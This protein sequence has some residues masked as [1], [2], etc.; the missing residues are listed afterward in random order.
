[1]EISE[2]NDVSQNRNILHPR[3]EYFDV[4]YN[5]IKALTQ[6]VI[7]THKNQI[8]YFLLY[9]FKLEIIIENYYQLFELGSKVNIQFNSLIS[10]ESNFKTN[11]CESLWYHVVIMITI[12]I[13]T[14]PE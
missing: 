2:V 10:V 8:D 6:F 9:S 3:N 1:M 14:S 4:S 5:T 7:N 13:P 11:S 12:A